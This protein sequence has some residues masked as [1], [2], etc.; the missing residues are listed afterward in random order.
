ML[1][2]VAEIKRCYQGDSS[3]RQPHPGP[4]RTAA[5]L[6]GGENAAPKFFTWRDLRR[7]RSK[8]R[9]QLYRAVHSS[10]ADLTAALEMRA[11]LAPLWFF[12]DTHRVEFVMVVQIGAIHDATATPSC[13]LRLRSA[14]R[15]QVL[16]V[17]SGC[18]S[19]SAISVCDIPSKYASS[20]T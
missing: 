6:N 7:S 20:M 12:G 15:T 2:A 3:G 10:H 18:P 8:Q 9:C 17:P 16:M 19:F 1:P 13:S 5:A 4:G 11:N 14:A